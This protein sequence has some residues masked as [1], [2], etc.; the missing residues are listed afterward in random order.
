MWCL[1]RGGAV[2]T[3]VR[4]SLIVREDDDEIGNGDVA[5]LLVLSDR[6]SNYT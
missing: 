2:A 4:V 3:D 6:S 1:Q 5:G